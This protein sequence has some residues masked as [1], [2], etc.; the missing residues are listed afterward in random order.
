MGEETD[1]KLDELKSGMIVN[2]EMNTM[3][4]CLLSRAEKNASN[5]KKFT[6]AVF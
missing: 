3:L 5:A 6:P 4:D 1:K 2:R